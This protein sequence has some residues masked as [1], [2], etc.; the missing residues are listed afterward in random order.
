MAQTLGA[1]AGT[2]STAMRHGNA[3]FIRIAEPCDRS[4]DGQ[5]RRSEDTQILTFCAASVDQR[6]NHQPFVIALWPGEIR[7]ISLELH[8]LRQSFASQVRTAMLKNAD[9]MSEMPF[10]SN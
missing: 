9:S 4:V 8:K 5:P 3:C 10:E 6:F 1:I 7:A 2:S